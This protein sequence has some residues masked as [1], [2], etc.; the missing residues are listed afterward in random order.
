MKTGKFITL[1]HY[2]NV[3]IGYGTVDHKEL[4]TIYVKLNS[5]L[6]PESENEKFDEIISKIRRKIKLR[7]YNLSNEFFKKESIVDLDIRTKGIKLGKKSFLNLEITLF[8]KKS[9]DFKSE[10]LK[11]FIEIL[12]KD[13]VDSDLNNKILFNFHENKK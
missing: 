9:F 12:I 2:K 7:I 4:K 8:T 11:I 5:W 3:K 6:A 1:N 13:I 10:E